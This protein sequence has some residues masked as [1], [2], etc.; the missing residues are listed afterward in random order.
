MSD[1]KRVWNSDGDDNDTEERLMM[2]RGMFEA[3][4]ARH[5]AAQHKPHKAKVWVAPERNAALPGKSM[6]AER[7][8]QDRKAAELA[9]RVDAQIAATKAM[10]EKE[11]RA[12]ADKNRKQQ[13]VVLEGLESGVW[14]LESWMDGGKSCPDFKPEWKAV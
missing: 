14:Q 2:N 13:K 12:K 9:A 4:G 11:A 5:G 10:Q 1:R 8:D 7:R 3:P 6:G